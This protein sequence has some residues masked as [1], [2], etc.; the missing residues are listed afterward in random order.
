VRYVLPCLA[1]LAL[2]AAAGLDAATELLVRGVPRA[3]RAAFPALAVVVVAYLAIVCVRIHP[4]YLDY[5][6]EQ[7]GGPA[8]VAAHRRFETA[9]WGEGVDRAVDYVNAHAAPGARVFR[10]C[11]EAS[12]LAWFRGDLWSFATRPADADWIIAYQPTAHRCDIPAGLRPVYTVDA[13]G[14]PLAIVYKKE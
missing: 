3:A 14:A 5:Y 2:I 9:W 7:V 11:I 13:Q 10:D 12:H 1:V 6:G 8:G 4:Y